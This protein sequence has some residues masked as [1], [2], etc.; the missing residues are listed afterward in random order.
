MKKK[1]KTAKKV[2]I[3]SAR[4][5]YAK[6][7]ARKSVRKKS[8]GRVRYT[9]DTPISVVEKKVGF[10]SG[11]PPNTKFGDYLKQNGQSVAADVLFSV[12]F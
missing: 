1:A 10:K 11:M 8:N 6:D 12:M 9:Y 5:R 3:D 7:S 4:K 2:A